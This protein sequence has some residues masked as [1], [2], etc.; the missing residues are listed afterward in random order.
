MRLTR[1]GEYA[2][3]ALI[4]LARAYHQPPVRMKHIAET[5]AIPKKY[6]EQILLQLK[7]AGYVA[8]ERGPD[9]GYRLAKAPP[10]INL[11]EIIRLVDGP[12][13]P[14]DSVS[15]YF[16]EHTPIEQH[17]K[18]HSVFKDIRNYI[19]DKLENIT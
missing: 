7:N 9:G 3:L 14:V 2:C 6:L 13:A 1:R 12:L 8:S 19:A 5:S 16:Y 11:A 17:P 15:V 18:L 10:E 4:H